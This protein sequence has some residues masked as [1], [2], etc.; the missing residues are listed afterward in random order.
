MIPIPQLDRPTA[1]G[2]EGRPRAVSLAIAALIVAGLSAITGIRIGRVDFLVTLATLTGLTAAGMT[3][4]DREAFIHRLFGYGLLSWFGAPLALII[5]AGPLYDR[6]G[7][8]TTGFALAIFGLAASWGNVADR[9][10][11]NR[12]VE[13]SGLTYLALWLWLA[14]FVV[15]GI[16]SW[17]LSGF[18]SLLT[19]PPGPVAALAGMLL[20]VLLAAAGLLCGIRWIPLRQLTPQASRQT[21]A[22]WLDITRQ[23]IIA[24]MVIAGGLLTLLVILLLGGTIDSVLTT[25]PLLA[26]LSLQ[27]SA[28]PVVGFLTTI[29]GVAF[30]TGILSLAARRLTR[31]STPRSTRRIAAAITGLPMAI[32]GLIGMALIGVIPLLGFLLLFAVVLAPVLLVTVLY[33]TST[34]TGV[35]LIPNRAGGPAIAATGLIIAAIGIVPDSILLAL[36]C[37]AAAVFVWDI[38]TFGLAVTAELGHRPDTLR[39]ELVHSVRSVSIAGAVI[40]LGTVIAYVA[41]GA[42][43]SVSGAAPALLACLGAVFLLAPIRG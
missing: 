18:I 30:F 29:G 20:L 14:V 25:V 9:D 35:G 40:L 26:D 27:L 32:A 7:L 39:L 11:L 31:Q 5:V 19:Q 4:L 13:A 28:W 16:T 38:V 41:Q 15:I 37:V 42:V 3:L 1:V 36:I 24:V 34:A 6:H 43:G 21:V 8:A 33:A 23:G 12:S 22:N 17:L 2:D 10:S